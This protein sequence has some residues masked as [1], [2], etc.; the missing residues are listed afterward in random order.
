MQEPGERELRDGRSVRLGGCVEFA[1]GASEFAG[2]NGE[3]G[4]EGDFVLGAVIDDVLVLAVA[5]VVLVLDAD[6]SMTLR[7][8]SISCGLTSLRPTWRILPCCWSCLMAPRDSSTGTLGSM[9]CSCQRSMRSSLEAAKAHLDFLDEVLG[10]ADGKP[11]VRALAGQ[12]GLGGDDDSFGVGSEGF[13]D[14]AL[15]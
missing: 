13:A 6:D 1:A 14:E 10:T 4:D 12:A 9:R 11:L 7:A 3:P 2:G 5:E 8:W 15:R